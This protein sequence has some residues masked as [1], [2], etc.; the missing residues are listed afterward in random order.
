MRRRLFIAGLIVAALVFAL[1]GFVLAE[2]KT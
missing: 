1:L 2:P